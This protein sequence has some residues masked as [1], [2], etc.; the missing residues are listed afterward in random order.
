MGPHHVTSCLQK[1][2][3][4]PNVAVNFTPRE[5]AMSGHLSKEALQRCDAA[6][7]PAPVGHRAWWSEA[8]VDLF[9]R[10]QTP[11]PGFDMSAILELGLKIRVR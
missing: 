1:M 2:V 11:H 6:D 3:T 5:V 7:L 10:M 9:G 4:F 8:C